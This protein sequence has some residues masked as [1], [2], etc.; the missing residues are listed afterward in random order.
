M[1]SYR[2]TSFQ[3]LPPIV[4]NLLIINGL[5]FLATIALDSS[6]GVSLT[7]LLGLHYFSSELFEPYQ[8]ITY[9]FMHGGFAHL[10]FNMFAIWM[11]GSAIENY[12]GP[13]RFFIYYIITGIGA[14]LLH[15][16]I[17][18]IEI[19]PIL[20]SINA[21]YET[22]NFSLIMDFMQQTDVRKITSQSGELVDQY[23]KVLS[24]QSVQSATDFLASLASYIKNAPVVVGAS[25]SLFGLLIAFGMMFPNREIY[26]YMAIPIKAKYFVAAYGALELYSGFQNNPGDNVAHFAHL[27]GMLFGFILIKYWKAKSEI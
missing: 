3:V 23:N 9:M 26:L 16:L 24:T 4:K 7:N 21:A 2:P 17:V 8:F 10:F 12:W 13:K 25:G 6:M 5:M 18:F 20:N 1:N 19:S 22:N 27:G 11:F 14:A 15:Y